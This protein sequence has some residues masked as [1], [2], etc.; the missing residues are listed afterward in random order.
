M[1]PFRL[2][3]FLQLRVASPFSVIL[4]N[5]IPAV[6]ALHETYGRLWWDFKALGAREEKSQSTVGRAAA[7]G[8]LCGHATRRDAFRSRSCAYLLQVRL[9]TIDSSFGSDPT[10]ASQHR[11][12]APIT[13]ASSPAPLPPGLLKVPNN[14][15]LD[16]LPR[17]RIH[18]TRSHLLVL[19]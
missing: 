13:A 1:H 9:R 18:Y 19:Y 8:L 5:R 16:V 10:R 7:E 15:I 14:K 12:S 6:C 17:L 3:F 4:L 2:K 11:P